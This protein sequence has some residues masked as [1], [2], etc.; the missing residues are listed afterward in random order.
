LTSEKLNVTQLELSYS[1]VKHWINSTL[2][3]LEISRA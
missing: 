3:R 1:S 2:Q